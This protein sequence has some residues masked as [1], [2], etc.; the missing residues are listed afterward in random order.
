MR[1]LPH[2]WSDLNF[3][4]CQLTDFLL[5]D[6][7]APS[8][9]QS[10]FRLSDSFLPRDCLRV[11]LWRKRLRSCALI[12]D[13]AQLRSTPPVCCEPDCCSFSQVC[14]QSVTN[15]DSDYPIQ[16]NMAECLLIRR[17]HENSYANM[18][19]ATQIDTPLISLTDHW[20]A[21]TY[22]DFTYGTP[23]VHEDPWR[24]PKS[25]VNEI[26]TYETQVAQRDLNHLYNCI[27]LAKFGKHH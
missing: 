18:L 14:F 10:G 22:Q 15:T 19:S 13:L 16:N 4:A 26:T 5:F 3:T 11:C 6:L 25:S 9:L 20:P 24:P 1:S 12:V 8:Q 2:C 21:H 17:Y 7:P 27:V 23:S